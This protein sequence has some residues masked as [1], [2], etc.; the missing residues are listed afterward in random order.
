MAAAKPSNQALDNRQDVND[1]TRGRQAR[2]LAAYMADKTV[3]TDDD[4]EIVFTTPTKLTIT[5]NKRLTE[6]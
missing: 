1:A 4:N 2:R 3:K 6:R 5:T